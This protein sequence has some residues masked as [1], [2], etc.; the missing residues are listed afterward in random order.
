MVRFTLKHYAGKNIFTNQTFSFIPG[1]ILVHTKRRIDALTF[2]HIHLAVV[3]SVSTYG[4]DDT[5]WLR[6]DFFL[7]NIVIPLS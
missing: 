6:K 5:I 4:I 7:L 3:Y 1:N 2:V